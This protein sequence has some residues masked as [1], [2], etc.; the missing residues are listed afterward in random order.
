MTAIVDP[1]APVHATTGLLPTAALRIPADQYVRAMQR[2]AV[3]FT[4]RP[5][6]RDTLELRLPLPAEPGFSWAWVA[7]GQPPAPLQIAASPD[8]PIY[9]YGPQRLLEGWLDLIPVAPENGNDDA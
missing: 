1:R 9:G 8:T 5:V 4:T 3:T 6:L 7:A 2:L